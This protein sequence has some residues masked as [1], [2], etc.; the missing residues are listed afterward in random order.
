MV[1]VDSSVW[2]DYFSAVENKHAWRLGMRCC[3]ALNGCCSQY[4][5]NGQC[6]FVLQ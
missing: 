2:I 6:G 4:F 3:G 5:V 1:V